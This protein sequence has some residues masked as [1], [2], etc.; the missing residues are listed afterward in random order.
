LKIAA[1][2]RTTIYKRTIC[3]KKL[4]AEMMSKT[5]LTMLVAAGLLALTG[6]RGMT[7]EEPTI[8]PIQD[9]DFQQKFEPQETN[10]FF[11]DAEQMKGA[12]QRPPVPGTVAR[13]FLREDN[14][15]YRGRTEN[16]DFVEEIPVPLSRELL[17]RGQERYNIYC[18]V[19][20][21]KAGD[22]NGIIM[23]GDYGYTPAPSYHIERLRN[24]KDGYIYNV[25]TNGVRNMPGY[26]QQVPVA[27]RWAIVAYVRA[28]QRSQHAE[29]EDVPPSALA[30]I[31]QGGSANMN[32]GR[33]GATGGSGGNDTTGT[34]Q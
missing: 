2:S 30:E 25:I 14:R 31:E 16:G 12:A 11:D 1:Q 6:C 7:W 29:R 26:A 33:Q 13:G 9:M 4:P 24:A 28:L 22:G 10:R 23:T 15:F 21:G 20:H 27:D 17:E 5:I 18:T 3:R 8:H 34:A 32:A 19:C